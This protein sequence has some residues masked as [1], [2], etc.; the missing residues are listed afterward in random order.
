MSWQ[1]LM[2]E[3]TTALRGG[4]H[5]DALQLCDRTAQM[6]DEARYHA[7]ILRGDVLLDLGDPSGA[8]SSYET[9]ADPGR[10]DPVVDCARGIALFELGR[11]AEADNALRSAI[12]GRPDLA[13][14]NFALAL[15]AEIQGSGLEVEYFRRARKLAPER[16]PPT[17]RLS[18]A[19]FDEALGAATTL[20]TDQEREALQN[21]TIFTEELPSFQDLRRG[22]VPLSP[23]SLAVL[24]PAGVAQHAMPPSGPGERPVLI[25]F[26]R[27]LERAARTAEALTARIKEALEHELAARDGS[28]D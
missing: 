4:R 7:A 8:L 17:P 28:P 11:F 16:F 20:L 22:T 12:R 25:L 26:K 2:E 24:V 5:H 9:V 21:I 19:E 18:R 3:A 14:A 27:N 10:P 13:E 6:G 23:L 15:M 1:K